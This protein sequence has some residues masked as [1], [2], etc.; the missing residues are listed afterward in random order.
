MSKTTL[1]LQE[2]REYRLQLQSLIDP[3][4][5]K[6]SELEAEALRPTAGAEKNPDKMPAHDADPETRDTEDQAAL[7][8]LGSEQH[9]MAEVTQALARLDAGTFGACEKCGHAITKARL[10]AVPYARNCIRCA[11]EVEA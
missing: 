1:S 9:I 10:D 11:R 4:K 5:E 8:I 3:L 2:L 6:I 7:A